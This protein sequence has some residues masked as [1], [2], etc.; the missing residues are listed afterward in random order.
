MRAVLADLST[1]RYLLTRA[2]RFELPESQLILRDAGG[3]E[4]LR[5]ATR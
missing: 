5:F 3:A 1:P 4:L 2:A